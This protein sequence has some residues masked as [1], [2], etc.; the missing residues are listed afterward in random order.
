[1]SGNNLFKAGAAVL[2]GQD[3]DC[4]MD[5]AL[6]GGIVYWC[7][8]IH[9]VGR[10]HGERLSEHISRNG[11]LV[12]YDAESDDSWKLTLKKFLAGF[13][14]WLKSGGDRYGAVEEDGTVDTSSIDAAGADC[15]VQYAL[16][17][18]VVFG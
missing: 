11:T 15:I 2:T 8:L 3:I 4:I 6:S 1:M 5:S 12:L 7:G 18:E 13:A 16:F 14:L 9:A 10:R 17:G